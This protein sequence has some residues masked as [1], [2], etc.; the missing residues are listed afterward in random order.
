MVKQSFDV[1]ARV[2]SSY[3]KPFGE[4]WLIA[5]QEYGVDGSRLIKRVFMDIHDII[6]ARRKKALEVEEMERKVAEEKLKLKTS[7][8]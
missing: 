2:R 1:D 8:I 4:A 6:L 5:K 7:G 3:K